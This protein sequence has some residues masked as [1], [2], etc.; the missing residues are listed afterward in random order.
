MEIAISAAI[1][2]RS[3]ELAISEPISPELVLVDPELRGALQAQ[4]LE[5]APLQ[6]LVNPE[7]EP[8]RPPPA[9]EPAP[10]ALSESPSLSRAAAAPA[11]V[12]VP[13]SEAEPPGARWVLGRPQRY[14]VRA[15]LPISLVLNAILIT[16]A[17]S[18]AT[19]SPPKEGR[20]ALSPAV[21]DTGKERPSLS[22]KAKR[23]P[24]STQKAP[25]LGKTSAASNRAARSTAPHLGARDP[26][27]ERKLLN[28]IVQAPAGK[29][30][31]ALIDSKT[32]LGKNNLHAVCRRSDGSRSF[33]CVVQPVRHKP[34]EGLYVR[35]RSN[36]KGTG[37]T[38]TSYHYRS[39]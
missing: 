13:L 9:P 34:G 38:F 36:R 1:A 39:G 17:V 27:L 25:A 2:A 20:P 3:A 30:P 19:V 35:Y 31:R 21:P 32:G 24:N 5:R 10:V 29:L 11:V 28:L 22:A 7:P 15:I 8:S 18:D 33:L 14:L 6:L 4:A 37:G 12:A 23:Q 26:R 16:L